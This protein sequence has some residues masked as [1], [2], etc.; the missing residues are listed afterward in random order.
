MIKK[1][2]KKLLYLFS[3]FIQTNFIVCCI[4][5]PNGFDAIHISRLSIDI[6]DIWTSLIKKELIIDLKLTIP[7]IGVLAKISGRSQ[8]EKICH[9][10]IV[11]KTVTTNVTLRNHA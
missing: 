1:E 6:K 11:P 2:K 8:V 9:A 3:A 7:K 4:L 10:K 5:Y